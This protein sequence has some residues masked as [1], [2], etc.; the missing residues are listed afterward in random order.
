MG[1]D[2]HYKVLFINK[3]DYTNKFFENFENLYR[4]CIQEWT[5]NLRVKISIVKD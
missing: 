2:Q 5:N 1:D 4:D 3:H